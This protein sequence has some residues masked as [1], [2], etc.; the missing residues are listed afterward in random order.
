L[1]QEEKRREEKRREEK[2]RE[3]KRREE[4]GRGGIEKPRITRACNGH[5]SFSLSAISS[6]NIFEKGKE[7]TV[8]KRFDFHERQELSLPLSPTLAAENP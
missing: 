8:V 7:E 4:E 1:N 2:R 3:E 5:F 6:A